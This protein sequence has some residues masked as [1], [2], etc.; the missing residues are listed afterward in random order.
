MGID[1]ENTDNGMFLEVSGSYGEF[2]DSAFIGAYKF[3][4]CH[5]CGHDLADWVGIKV[6]NWH[7]HRE[8][9]GMHPD[10]HDED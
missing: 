1:S 10:H 5:S 4:L 7:T 8:G 3:V 9:S 2:Y 6:N